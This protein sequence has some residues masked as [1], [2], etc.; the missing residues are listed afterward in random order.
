MV[1][2]H[3]GP[4]AGR[5]DRRVVEPADVDAYMLVDDEGEPVA[6]GELW[7][8]D[9]EH[10]VARPAHRRASWCRRIG[11][12]PSGRRSDRRRLLTMVRVLRRR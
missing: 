3:R 4:G 11:R 7:I 8:D 10:E 6:Y 12:Q 9:D 1:L 2:A 5:G